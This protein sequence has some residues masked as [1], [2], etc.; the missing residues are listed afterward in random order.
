MY[1][2]PGTTPQCT[3]GSVSLTIV[4]KDLLSDD[5]SSSTGAGKYCMYDFFE[6]D[7]SEKGISCLDAPGVLYINTNES[8]SFKDDPKTAS[9]KQYLGTEGSNKQQTLSFYYD[10][11]NVSDNCANVFGPDV[12]CDITQSGDSKHKTYTL[13]I[14]KNS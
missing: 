2:P 13:T 14:S 5:C 3:S 7:H 6:R 8:V 11:G 1:W 4:N 10:H 9:I 12:K